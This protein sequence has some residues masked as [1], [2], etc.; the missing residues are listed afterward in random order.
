MPLPQGCQS[1]SCHAQRNKTHIDIVHLACGAKLG[2]TK[3]SIRNPGPRV[4]FVHERGEATAGVSP[5]R[6]RS[7][8]S[9]SACRTNARDH[10]RLR[11]SRSSSGHSIGDIE[12]LAER[13]V[14]VVK[15]VERDGLVAIDELYARGDGLAQPRGAER[16]AGA[17]RGPLSLALTFLAHTTAVGILSPVAA[18]PRACSACL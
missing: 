8:G 7:H 3:Q 12:G 6:W 15:H 13:Q 17:S 18:L 2:P 5:S 14:D 9:V 16:R 4:S 10:Q 1:K 11:R